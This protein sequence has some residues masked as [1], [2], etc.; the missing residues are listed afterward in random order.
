[1]QIDQI[2]QELRGM[3]NAGT[4]MPGFRKKVMVE[5]DRL[6]QIADELKRSVPAN[7]AEASEIVKQKESLINLAYMEAERIKASAA[8]EANALSS[9]A[10]QEHNARVDDSEIIRAAEARAE[11]I[12]EEAIYES[13][14]IVQEA[15]R[16]A[17]RLLNEAES[18]AM[19][20][21]D[22]AD[23]YA[24]EVL[25][26]LEEQLAEVLGQVRRGIDALRIEVE[27]SA[28]ASQQVLQD[29]P[30]ANGVNGHSNGHA[31]GHT[32]ANGRMQHVGV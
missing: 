6:I 17:Y 8:E 31:N 11:D 15:Q 10:H 7:M 29:A 14:Q 18:A 1:M 12:K 3:A 19:A 28:K 26:N 4:R 32:K 20:R 5:G 9:A 2:V 30:K 22:G 13:Q 23:N 16:K 21:R 27:A 25:F 24:K